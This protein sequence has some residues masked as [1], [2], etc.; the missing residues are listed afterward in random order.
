MLARNLISNICAKLID[1]LKNII[2]SQH[3][4]E[5][6]RNSPKDFTR[7]RKLPFHTLILFMI[8]RIKGSYQ[9]E[10]DHYFKAILNLDV[11]IQQVTKMAFCKARRKLNFSAFVELN[12]HLIEYFYTKFKAKKWKGF[13]LLAI[14][15]S[16][17]K[18]LK[19]EEIIEHFG[20]LKPKNG[21]ACPMARISQLFDVLNKVTVDAIINP[22]H[23]GERELM[24]H[25]LLK[26]LP[27]DLLLL[28]RGYPA[29]WIF[30]LILSLD[31]NFCARISRR[32]NIIKDFIDSGQRETIISLQASYVSKKECAEM[33]IDDTPLQLRLIRI[34]LDSGEVEVLITSLTDE[35]QYPHRIF[36]ELYHDRWPV[37][38]DYKVMKTRIE[39]GNFSGESVLS[40]YQDFHAKVLAKNLT[41]VIAFPAQEV[42]RKQS[43]EKKYEYQINFT[44]AVSK[45]K[46]TVILL[47]ERSQE[48]A[49]HIIKQLHDVFISTIEP[50]RPDRKFKRNHQINKR[51]YYMNYKPCR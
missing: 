7:Q 28:D 5:R 31:G 2:H 9:D 24:K 11:V 40:V 16:T 47:F 39:I 13:N 12:D 3:F 10:L 41:F 36:A 14:D 4:L 38:E 37:E 19:Y 17:L 20:I 27:N 51:E 45:S 35:Q 23:V 49:L 6:H 18:L 15:G 33:G 50:I 43:Q 46:D 21:P 42:V 32:W 26:L 34:E 29:F 44:Q 22:Y 25:H 48:I 30:S 8:N 1:Y